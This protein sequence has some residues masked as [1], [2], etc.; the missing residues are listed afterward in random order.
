[1]NV[2]L[3]KALRAVVLAHAGEV[4]R[5]GG[6]GKDLVSGRR[7]ACSPCEEAVLQRVAVPRTGSSC[8]N[9]AGAVELAARAPTITV[10][11]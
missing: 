8:L 3:L 6:T 5:R 9:G 4:P 7:A 1:V 10:P 2:S 11:G